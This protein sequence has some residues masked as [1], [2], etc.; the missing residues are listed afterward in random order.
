MCLPTD[1]TTPPT[2]NEI[3]RVILDRLYDAE[4]LCS[5]CGKKGKGHGNYYLPSQLSLESVL[6]AINSDEY[7]FKEPQS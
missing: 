4:C 7:Y 2:M 1:T 5:C 6:R 3:K